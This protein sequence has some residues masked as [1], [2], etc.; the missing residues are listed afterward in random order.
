MNKMTEKERAICHKLMK[1]PVLGK[2]STDAVYFLK[3]KNNVNGETPVYEFPYQGST[4][5]YIKLNCF[6]RH[7]LKTLQTKFPE[8]YEKE[9]ETIYNSICNK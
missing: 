8:I 7:A 6:R 3:D 5:P 2:N 9:I 4:I 1:F